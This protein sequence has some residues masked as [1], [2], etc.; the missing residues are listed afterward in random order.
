M[1]RKT[2]HP[3]LSFLYGC[4]SSITLPIAIFTGLV[5]YFFTIGG[6]NDIPG[7]N[8]FRPIEDFYALDTTS[9]QTD[10]VLFTILIYLAAYASAV[11]LRLGA[12]T[13]ALPRKRTLILN[14]GFALAAGFSFAGI[15]SLFIQE[16]NISVLAGV[17]AGLI[18]TILIIW[19]L[20]KCESIAA[21]MLTSLSNKSYKSKK[22]QLADKLIGLAIRIRPENPELIRI[23]GLSLH[24]ANKNAKALSY[25][26]ILYNPET[27]DIEVLIALDKAYRECDQNEQAMHILNHI[28]K[29]QPDR[30]ESRLEAANTLIK[31]NQTDQAIQTLKQ[32]PE[33]NME[34]LIK[35]LELEIQ[36][37]YRQQAQQTCEK[38]EKLDEGTQKQAIAAWTKFHNKWPESEEGLLA[39]GELHIQ[40]K[41]EEE[42]YALFERI[43]EIDPQQSELRKKLVQYYKKADKMAQ[44]EPHLTALMDAGDDNIEIALLYG[45]LLVQREDYDDALLHFQYAIESYPDDY[46]FPYFLSQIHLKSGALEDAMQRVEQAENIVLKNDEAGNK[47]KN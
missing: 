31:L 33:P 3:I 24:K 38:I 12:G 44:A 29:I 14:I 13:A 5:V 23:L 46:R 40:H 22:F 27:Q 36:S 47:E 28:L 35:R 32:H 21:K 19:A 20:G 43:I 11:L 16:K 45:D 37:G 8:W 9:P 34:M 10:L 41:R 1:Q 30:I 18:A 25:L 2:R 26:E 39:L 42:G 15:V 6:I 17:I 7:F 4:L